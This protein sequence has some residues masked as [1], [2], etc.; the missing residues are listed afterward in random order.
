[1]RTQPN[2]PVQVVLHAAVL[3]VH[4]LKSRMLELGLHLPQHLHDMGVP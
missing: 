2:G 4:R 3:R 1:L